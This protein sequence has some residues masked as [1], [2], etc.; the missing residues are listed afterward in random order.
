MKNRSHPAT[1][2]APNAK[3][4]TLIAK[5]LLPKVDSSFQA[6]FTQQIWASNVRKRNT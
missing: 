4:S 6:K 5:G 1:N 3:A 2:G